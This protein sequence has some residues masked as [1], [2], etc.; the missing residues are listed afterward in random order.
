[1][2]IT[3]TA[4]HFDLTNA[5]RDYIEDACKK[6]QK[7]FEQI[8]NVHLILTLEGG[9]NVVEMVLHVPK[10]N[11]KSE[12]TEQDMYL[13]IDEAVE[14]ME[15]QIKKLKGKWTDHKKKSMKDNTSFVYANLIEKQ[16]PRKRIKTKR[17]VA[18]VMSIHEA[19]DKFEQISDPYLI[20]KNGETDR[21]NV[22]VKKDEDHFKLL[23]P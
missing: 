18:E 6:L 12:S 9:R 17:I 4:R 10:S 21:I 3:I 11:F 13:A 16:Q 23:E 22:L 5:I 7:Y 8:I 2:Q 19:I 1:M 20:F 14:K 15:I